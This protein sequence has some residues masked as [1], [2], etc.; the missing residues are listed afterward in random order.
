MTGWESGNPS[1]IKRLRVLALSEKPVIFAPRFGVKQC[2]A[3]S[4]FVAVFV[5]CGD[6]VAASPRGRSPRKL[7]GPPFQVAGFRHDRRIQEEHRGLPSE[8]PPYP[9]RGC[10]VGT[11]ARS[12]NREKPQG[13]EPQS[14]LVGGR[15]GRPRPTQTAPVGGMSL[16][17]DAPCYRAAHPGGQVGAPRPS[18]P[19]SPWSLVRA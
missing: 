19:T 17:G 12:P 9:L 13:D 11:L 5:F 18:R 8:F 2:K 16:A 4:G 15:V 10:E 7:V 1:I 6:F 14:V 3:N